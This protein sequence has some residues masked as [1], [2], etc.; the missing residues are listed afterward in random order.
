MNPDARQVDA[1]TSVAHEA[2]LDHRASLRAPEREANRPP[3]PATDLAPEGSLVT[4]PRARE[5]RSPTQTRDAEGAAVESSK[6]SVHDQVSSSVA[7]S[8]LSDAR[9]DDG[10]SPTRAHSRSPSAAPSSRASLRAISRSSLSAAALA[11]SSVPSGAW[12]DISTWPP[13]TAIHQRPVER[14]P[15]VNSATSAYAVSPV[16]HAIADLS[17]CSSSQSESGDFPRSLTSPSRCSRFRRPSAA[18]LGLGRVASAG[19]SAGTS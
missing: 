7:V 4:H 6:G 18:V 5:C 10:S 14:A 8:R 2:T 16:D 12:S 15:S 3:P 13:A 9:R 1:L 11:A 17:G 19:G